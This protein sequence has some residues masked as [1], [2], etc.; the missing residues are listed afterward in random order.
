[1]TPEVSIDAVAA[2][3]LAVQVRSILVAGS[4]EYPS[5]QVALQLSVVFFPVHVPIV[6]FSGA[7]GSSHVAA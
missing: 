6:P 3:V 7:V 4:A 1:M 2:S 5:L